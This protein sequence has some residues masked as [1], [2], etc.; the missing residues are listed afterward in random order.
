MFVVMLAA[1][2]TLAPELRADWA[3]VRANNRM[4]AR[5]HLDFEAE[6]QYA[7]YWAGFYPGMVVRALPVGYVQASVGTTGYY[8][9]NGV[10]FRPTTE[11]TY[12][13]VA[14]PVGAVVPQLP[15]GAEAIV[16]GSA[17][18]YYAASAFYLQQ[19]NGFGVVAA[20]LGVTVPALP[21][22]ATPAV[23]NGVLYYVTGSTYFMPVMQAGVTVYVTAHP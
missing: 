11:S 5:K 6:R 22:G 9:Y 14:P 4:G 20:P 21:A 8:Y 18:Y 15:E 3:S 17:T 2:C 12:E 10:Y 7:F 19:S 23:I 16:I 1:M 13:V